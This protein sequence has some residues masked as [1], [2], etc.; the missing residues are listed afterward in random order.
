MKRAQ[1]RCFFAS[2]IQFIQENGLSDKLIDFFPKADKEDLINYL[3]TH[4]V[5]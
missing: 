2:T 3:G 4:E 5:E 1:L